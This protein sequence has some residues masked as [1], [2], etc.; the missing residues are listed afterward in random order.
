MENEHVISGLKRKRAELAGHIR[1]A[2]ERLERLRAAVASVDAT[3]QLFDPDIDPAAIAPKRPYKR[4]EHFRQG[5]LSRTILD[6][7]RKAERPLGSQDVIGAIAG[8]MGYGSKPPAGMAG[9]IRASLRYLAKRG[10]VIRGGERRAATWR[11][12]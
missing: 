4:P 8:E 12:I 1:E 3:L 7:L 6:I 5:N 2:K 9:N 11:V 10:A